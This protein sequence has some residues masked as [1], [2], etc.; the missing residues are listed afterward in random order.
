VTSL[1]AGE[2]VTCTATYTVTQADVQA[3]RVT[4][5]AV[6]TARTAAG[7]QVDSPSS[8][9]ELTTRQPTVDSLALKKTAQV[10]DTNHNKRTDPGDVINW[11][12]TVTNTGG[13]T[14][15]DIQVSDP[16][17]GPVT[18]P[19]TT[20]APGASMTC[21]AAPYTIT[22]RDAK[23]GH[24]TDTATAHGTNAAGQTITSNEASATVKV[25]FGHHPHPRPPHKH[26]RPPHGGHRPPQGGHWPPHGGHRPPH[27]GHH[28]H[29]GGHR[30]PHGGHHGGHRPSHGGHH[31]QHHR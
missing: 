4:N 8:S 28:P 14:L 24:V 5:T 25:R 6:A 27:G 22:K 17:A 26:P 7:A 30:P 11:T 20:L 15:H 12:L 21:R 31:P 3:G 1:D 18:C 9:A 19:N 16:T 23:R 29:H 13:G 2:S 10:T